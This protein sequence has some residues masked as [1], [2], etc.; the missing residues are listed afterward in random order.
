MS[1]E[2]PAKL[3]QLQFTEKQALYNSYMVYCRDGGLFVPTLLTLHLGSMI[4]LMVEIPG[5]SAMHM[6]SGK[7][8]WLNQNKRKGVGLRL[9]SD[10][11]SR[12][13]KTA[14]E[15]TLGGLLKGSNPTYTM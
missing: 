3:L 1:L 7:V 4:H 6:V 11:F 13:L 5:D 10:E 8:V 12:A 14:I 2:H 15:N 9:I